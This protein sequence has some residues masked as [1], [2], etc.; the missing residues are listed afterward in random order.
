MLDAHFSLAVIRTAFWKTFNDG[1]DHW[2]RNEEY[3]KGRWSDFVLNLATAQRERLAPAI[4]AI[5]A[6][7]GVIGNLH[8]VLDVENYKDE[9]LRFCADYNA[10]NF[11]EMTDDQLVLERGCLA[12]LWP[13]TLG[14]RQMAK[15]QG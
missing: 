12:A 4:A 7:E 15:E 1:S 9:D 8:I 11:H 6:L 2:F 13:L 3:T 5:H 10:Q 14:E